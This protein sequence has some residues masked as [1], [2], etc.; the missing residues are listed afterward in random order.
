MGVIVLTG[1]FSPI[2]NSPKFSVPWEYT[3]VVVYCI[4]S[5]IQSLAPLSYAILSFRDKRLVLKNFHWKY[6][7]DVHTNDHDCQKKAVFGRG[8][9][10]TRLFNRKNLISLLG[11]WGQSSCDQLRLPLFWR[12]FHKKSHFCYGRDSPDSLSLKR[13][14]TSVPFDLTRTINRDWCHRTETWNSLIWRVSHKNKPFLLRSRFP[15]LSFIDSDL[16][17]YQLANLCWPKFWPWTI[18]AGEP[19]LAK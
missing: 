14:V 16:K 8:G 2:V 18:P 6:S 3:V 1:G 12:V 19:M 11:C 10:P 17:Q 5:K 9:G 15:R 7:F 4:K 13:E